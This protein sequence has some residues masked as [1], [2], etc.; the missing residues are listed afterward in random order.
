MYI[1]NWLAPCTVVTCVENLYLQGQQFLMN[2]G[3]QNCQLGQAYFIMELIIAY[4]RLFKR[5]YLRARFCKEIVNV[6]S[7]AIPV[8]D[9]GGL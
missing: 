2:M 9:S 3:C 4:R 6:E 7:L 8:T 1:A 5:H